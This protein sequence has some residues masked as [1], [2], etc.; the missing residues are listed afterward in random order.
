MFI[1]DLFNILIII[2]FA[3]HLDTNGSPDSSQR[4]RLIVNQR[5]KIVVVDLIIPG[6]D[7]VKIIEGK[8]S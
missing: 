1:K 5:E 3:R 2:M 7:I 6:G 8:K 4:A